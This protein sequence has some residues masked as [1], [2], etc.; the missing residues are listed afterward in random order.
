[1]DDI[2]L[3]IEAELALGKT[4]K[5]LAEKYSKSYGTILGWQKKLKEKNSDVD[6]VVAIEPEIL[7]AVAARIKAEAPKDVAKKIDA[8]VDGVTSLQSLEPKFHAVVLNLLERAEELSLDK[9]LS[10]R[11]WAALGNGIGQLY[12][13]IFNKSGVNVNVLNNTQVNG[14]KMQL[15]KSSMSK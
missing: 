9:E 15:F 12:T 7:H 10:I 4:P 3:K 11:D 13:N 1:M 8:V 6:T 5:D 14:E 2:R